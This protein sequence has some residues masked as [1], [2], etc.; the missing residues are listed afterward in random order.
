[1]NNLTL[2][3]GHC[4]YVID[5]PR[6][7][8]ALEGLAYRIAD[9]NYMRD[10]YGTTEAAPELAENKKTISSIF[11]NLDNLGVPFWVQNA[12][13]CWAEHWQNY[14]GQYIEAAFKNY[15]VK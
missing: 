7:K 14:K 13:I 6:V 2:Q 4:N 12:V 11:D 5:D 8:N 10:R 3:C 1:M 9:T 15:I